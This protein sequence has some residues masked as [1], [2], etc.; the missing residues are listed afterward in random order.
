AAAGITEPNFK[1]ALAGR[2]FGALL[3][4]VA[5]FVPSRVVRPRRATVPVNLLLS[6]PRT[7]LY[8]LAVAA[9]SPPSA[10][11]PVPEMGPRIVLSPAPL[12]S[13]MIAPLGP[14]RML[15]LCNV[16]GPLATAFRILAASN[17]RLLI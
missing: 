17:V 4:A 6:P 3:A 14:I 13:Q 1:I 8:G 9:S 16:Q 10:S 7:L 15:L 12:P 5:A 2:A 11:T